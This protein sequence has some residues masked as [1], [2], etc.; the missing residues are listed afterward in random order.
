MRRGLSLSK[1]SLSKRMRMALVAGSVAG[2][3]GLVGGCGSG[4]VAPAVVLAPTMTTLLVTSTNNAQIPIFKFNVVGVSLVGSD[5]TTTVNLMSAPQVVEMGSINGVARPLATV[6]V[7]QGSYT[8]VNLTYGASGFVVID[9]SAG[10]GS[11]DFGTYN[12]NLPTGT[13]SGANATVK[14]TLA[15]PL[16]VSGTAMGVLL[17]LN[18]PKST[19]FTPYLS[20]STNM[21]GGQ[22]SFS[23]L[24][25]MS[26]VTIAAQPSTLMD[27][28]VQDVHGQVKASAGGVLTLT[29]DTGSTLNFSTGAGTV[30]AGASGTTAP[31]VGSYVDVDGA[32]QQD[33]TMLATLVQTEA[34]TLAYDLVGPIVEYTNQ[35]FLLATGREQQGPNLPDGTGFYI[36]H[37]E[38]NA[39]PQFEI[40]WPNGMAAA[41]LP[42]TPV[43]DVGSI[44]AGQNLA[45]PIAALQTTGLVIPPASVVTLEGQTIDGTV[46]GMSTANGQTTY[47]VSLFA[48]DLISIFGPAK[49]VTVYATAGT[50]VLTAAAVSAGAVGRF[51]GLLFD[52]GG[53]C[54]WWRRRSRTAFRVPKAGWLRGRET[55]SDC[56]G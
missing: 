41:G 8:A 35:Q 10:D 39:T 54:G 22:T 20:G 43:L 12:V 1:L 3:V 25:T 29:S 46:T 56:K 24:F 45:T 17:D 11:I 28:A 2:A 55:A 14:M 34:T 19:T 23:P 18:I 33:G 49:T 5:G 31:P 15:T 48:D 42:F 51:H 37:I 50:H 4:P 38:F 40:A 32:L 44:A 52:D 6:S 26:G 53:R 36:N 47:Q 30:F 16:E 21:T 9:H 7:P 13:P 27:G